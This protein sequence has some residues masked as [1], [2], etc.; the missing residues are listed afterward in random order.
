M[1]IAF[2]THLSENSSFIYCPSFILAVLLLTIWIEM[3]I[4]PGCMS[5]LWSTIAVTRTSSCHWDV[6]SSPRRH[7]VAVISSRHRY[8][9]SSQWRYFR[10]RSLWSDV[11]ICNN[12]I[13]IFVNNEIVI[14]K[15]I[16]RFIPVHVTI[17]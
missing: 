3:I 17:T 11:S 12:K 9:I 16:P 10:L 2:M 15:H 8:V 14:F 1:L 6:I 4:D 7:L 13:T 5:S